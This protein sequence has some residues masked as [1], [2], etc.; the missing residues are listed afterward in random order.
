M[1]EDAQ[2]ET[3]VGFEMVEVSDFQSKLSPARCPVFY[4][5]SLRSRQ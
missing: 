4:E 5:K 2:S 1:G 3:K